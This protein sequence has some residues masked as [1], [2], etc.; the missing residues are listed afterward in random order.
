[1]AAQDGQLNGTELGVYVGGTLIA[2][3]TSATLNINHSTRATSS[4]ES[5]GWEENMEGFRNWDVSCDS[6]Y[7]WLDPAG[8]AISN[9]TLSDMFTA[10]IDTRASFTLTFGN[11][12]TTGIGW[13][14]Y[15]GTAWM[16]SASISAPMEDTA[17]FSVS[18]QGSGALTQ[19]IDTTP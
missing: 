4:K 17:T 12:S 15:V 1:M 9:K 2:Y 5:S 13:T 16:T 11:T 19:T 3:S 6:L 14:K 7:A 10:Y 18:F 8:S